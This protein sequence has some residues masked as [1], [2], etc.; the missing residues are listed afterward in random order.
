MKSD[1]HSSRSSSENLSPERAFLDAMQAA[2]V[3]GSADNLDLLTATARRAFN[4]DGIPDSLKTLSQWTCWHYQGKGNRKPTKP[5]IDART[6]RYASSKDPSTWSTFDAALARFHADSTIA[7]LNLILTADDQIVAIDIDD[8]GDSPDPLAELA[9]SW[10]SG[11]YAEKSPSGGLH[12]FAIGECPG[13]SVQKAGIF[14]VKRA[15]T[16]T[17]DRIEGH[18]A[19]LTEQQA[20]ID[21]YHRHCLRDEPLPGIDDDDGYGEPPPDDCLSFICPQCGAAAEWPDCERCGYDLTQAQQPDP[22]DTKKNIGSPPPAFPFV[23]VG[24]V[25]YARRLELALTNSTISALYHGDI[26]AYGDRSRAEQALALRLLTFANGDTAVVAD[27]LNGSQCGK[28]LERSKDSDVYRRNTLAAAL[29]EWDRKPF[30]D[31][32]Q[33]DIDH[34]RLLAEA[35]LKGRDKAGHSDRTQAGH[36]PP[37]TGQAGTT[38]TDRENPLFVPVSR[39]IGTPAPPQWTV[40]KWLPAASMVVLF[41]EPG[42]GKSFLAV[43]WC[44]HVATGQEWNGNRVKQGAVLYIAG[45]GHYGLRR[46]FATWQQQ[47]GVI[48]DTLYISERAVTLDPAGAKTVFKA[49]GSIDEIPVLIVVDTL[50]SV[51]AGDENN[52]VDMNAF[53]TVLKKLLVGTAATILVVHHTGHGSKDRA[54]GHSSLKAALDA[55]FRAERCDESGTLTCTKPKDMEP[56]PPLSF[57]LTQVELPDAWRDPEEPDEAVTSCIFTVTGNAD[58]KPGKARELPASQKIAMT[59]LHTALV[60][61]GGTFAGQFAVHIDAWRKAT[62][63]GGIADTQVAKKKAFQRIRTALLASGDVKCNDDLYWFADTGKQ[64]SASLLNTAKR[65]QQAANADS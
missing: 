31:P 15:L 62:Y 3:A 42:C 14:E 5:P 49:V 24:T 46:R 17:G 22:T 50:S 58:G 57:E 25:D 40:R 19:N 13:K 26:S 65:K 18:A 39:F 51:I 20:G 37:D 53:L 34:G 28:W 8:Y 55:E 1:T 7:G 38:G 33:P 32:R 16:V 41:G 52:A 6:G 61:E 44:C 56:P 47:H 9:L 12:I 36:E 59:A 23:S 63:D 21:L 48:P 29:R 43:D 30:I 27:W 35:L 2:V 45:E 4:P 10:F 64:N 11:T 60:A 54:R